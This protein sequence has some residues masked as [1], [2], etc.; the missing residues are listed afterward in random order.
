MDLIPGRI[1]CEKEAPV[2]T[3]ETGRKH[4]FCRNKG[5]YVT[6]LIIATWE[7]LLRQ[8]N[9]FKERSLLRQGNVC[10]DTERRSIC[11]DKVMYVAT[12]RKKKS[13]CER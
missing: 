9:R 1:C 12:R 4:K 3:N 11:R 2:A 6:T 8:K 13:G 10:R 5:S 7:S